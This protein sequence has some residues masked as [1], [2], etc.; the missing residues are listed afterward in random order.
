[1]KLRSI[2]DRVYNR[3]NK[4]DGW[5]QSK[6]LNYSIRFNWFRSGFDWLMG[7]NYYNLNDW[8]SKH[9]FKHNIWDY[10]RDYPARVIARVLGKYGVDL[11]NDDFDTLLDFIIDS[12]LVQIEGMYLHEL[13]M[14]QIDNIVQFVELVKEYFYNNQ[15]KG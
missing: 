5:F 14:H 8:G 15:D 6:K 3:T 1:M 7:E 11:A 4:N 9:K 12:G 2:N 10:V 13:P